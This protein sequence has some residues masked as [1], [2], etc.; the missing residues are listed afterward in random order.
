MIILKSNTHIKKEIVCIDTEFML[1]VISAHD[2]SY[3]S[4][5][6]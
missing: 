5:I 6:L 4:K 2:K 3:H 1:T